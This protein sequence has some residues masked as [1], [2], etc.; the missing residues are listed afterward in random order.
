ML[1]DTKKNVNIL[2]TEIKNIKLKD[3]TEFPQL[4]NTVF[5]TEN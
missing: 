3:H 5:V 2:R 4:K 1:K